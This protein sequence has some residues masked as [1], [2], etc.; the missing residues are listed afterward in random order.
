MRQ[1]CLYFA[2]ERVNVHADVP[3]EYAYLAAGMRVKRRA[4]FLAGRRAAHRALVRAGAPAGPVMRGNDSAPQW[5]EGWSGSITHDT[6]RALAVAAPG[7]VRIGV[8]L[9]DLTRVQSAAAVSALCLTSSEMLRFDTPRAALCAFSAKEAVYKAMAPDTASKFWLAGIHLEHEAP[10]LLSW[11]IP[12]IQASGYA[13]VYVVRDQV[14]SLAWHP[15]VR[16]T[17]WLH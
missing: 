10:N 5:P 3:S 8:D 6:R 16:W 1:P 9:E 2:L 14:L 11:T 7:R 17:S 15:P 12:D 13:N 4:E